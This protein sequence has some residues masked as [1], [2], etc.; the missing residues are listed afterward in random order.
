MY[1]NPDPKQS[2]KFDRSPS[3]GMGMGLRSDPVSYQGKVNP[4]PGTH[5]MTS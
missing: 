2:Y 1:G 5:E 3:V 4:G